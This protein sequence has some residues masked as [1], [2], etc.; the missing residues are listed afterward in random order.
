MLHIIL[1]AACPSLNTF[2]HTVQKKQRH[3]FKK[4]CVTKN[5]LLLQ[6]AFL[7]NHFYEE[8]SESEVPY[9]IATKKLHIVRCLFI[10][11]KVQ[12]LVARWKHFRS[13][14]SAI[15]VDDAV[16][17]WLLYCVCGHKK[18]CGQLFGAGKFLS[19]RPTAQF[20]HLQTFSSSP[21]RK[22]SL[23]QAIQITC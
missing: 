16:P 13:S 20:W 17:Q 7:Q 12:T 11:F 23:C 15:F 6:L 9:F 18:S 8:K 1:S 19:T 21:K 4:G 5:V 10:Y 3:V 22:T 2:F 14:S